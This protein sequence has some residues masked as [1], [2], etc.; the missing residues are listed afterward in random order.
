M[1][2]Y[3]YNESKT[4]GKYHEVH[5]DSCSHLPSSWNRKDLGWHANCREAIQTAQNRT[6]D[7]DFDGCA[8]CCNDCHNG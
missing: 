3:L 8:Y 5:T 1:P 4:D 6:G 7:Y 2:T